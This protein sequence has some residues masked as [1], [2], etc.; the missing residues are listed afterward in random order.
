MRIY[1]DEERMCLEKQAQNLNKCFQ[2][3]L[4]FVFE[5]IFLEKYS[6]LFTRHYTPNQETSSHLKTVCRS[7]P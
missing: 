4:L 5:I 7:L 3:V 1:N 6:V 2:F